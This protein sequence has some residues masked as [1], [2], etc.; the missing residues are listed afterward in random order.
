M[1]L[2]CLILG[3]LFFACA[4]P[5]QPVFRAYAATVEQTEGGRIDTMVA[6]LG[7]ERVTVRVPHGYSAQVQAEKMS[8]VFTDKAGTTAITLRMT[9]NSPGVMPEDDA[10]R[11]RA[12]AAN[13]GGTFL[14]MST[15]ATGYL[16]AKYVDSL[17]TV[18]PDLSLKVRHAF[19]A[20]PEGA[21]EVVCSANGSAFEDA[22]VAF[23][24]LMSSLRVEQ[25]KQQEPRPA[26]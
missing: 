2:A 3:S 13:P 19:L 25:V 9:T 10:L 1:R 23:N 12:L 15:C 16:P 11:D 7:G 14:E 22:R 6:L 20:C 8:V 18:A 24:A 5:A 4:G 26:P 21:V 17:R